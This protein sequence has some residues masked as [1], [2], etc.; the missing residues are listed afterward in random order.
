MADSKWTENNFFKS[1]KSDTPE[2]WVKYKKKCYQA[3]IEPAR[4]VCVCV[5]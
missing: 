4:Y 3:Y 5:Y 1:V 2:Y